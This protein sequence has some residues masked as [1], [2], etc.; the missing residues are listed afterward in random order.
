MVSGGRTIPHQLRKVSEFP[1]ME[2]RWEQCRD[3][4]LTSPIN[5]PT[6]T[7]TISHTH[8]HHDQKNKQTL[9]SSKLRVP[10]TSAS[11]SLEFV[12]VLMAYSGAT[13]KKIFV[14]VEVKTCGFMDMHVILTAWW[15]VGR[16]LFYSL[17]KYICTSIFTCRAPAYPVLNHRLHFLHTYVHHTA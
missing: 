9:N 4:T 13:P 15:C 11:N 16:Y 5:A 14:P 8:T 10:A 7:S 3:I 17:Q 2:N 1:A 12:H 6:L